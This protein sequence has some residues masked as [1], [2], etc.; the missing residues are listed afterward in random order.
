MMAVVIDKM[1]ELPVAAGLSVICRLFFRELDR[2]G[3]GRL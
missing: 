2:W 3:A 1:H